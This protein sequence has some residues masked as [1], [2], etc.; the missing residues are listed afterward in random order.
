MERAVL[1]WLDN[2]PFP[3]VCFACGSSFSEDTNQEMTSRPRDSKGTSGPPMLF[4]EC[5]THS[6]NVL[7]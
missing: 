3:G 7:R 4:A 2:Q 1:P 6:G 5:T